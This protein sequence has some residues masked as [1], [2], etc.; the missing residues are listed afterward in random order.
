MIAHLDDKGEPIG[1][2]EIFNEFDGNISRKV[3]FVDVTTKI[4]YE[5]YFTD[6]KSV[7]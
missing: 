7:V 3:E 6:R 1:T 5:Y 4:F 2:W